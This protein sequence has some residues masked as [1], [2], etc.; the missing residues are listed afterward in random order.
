MSRPKST[1]TMFSVAAWIVWLV[2]L[3]IVALTHRQRLHTFALVFG[4][5]AIG[6]LGASIAR[7]VYPPPTFRWPGRD[8]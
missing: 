4:G 3:G 1:Y 8:A 5:W 2:L 6:W 7:V